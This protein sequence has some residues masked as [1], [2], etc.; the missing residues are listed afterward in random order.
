MP[1]ETHPNEPP[2]C[3]RCHGA[4]KIYRQRRQPGDGVKTS[5]EDCPRCNG[6]GDE[7]D[8]PPE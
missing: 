2:S 3:S 1:D 4:K 5:K 8:E 7:P 6:T